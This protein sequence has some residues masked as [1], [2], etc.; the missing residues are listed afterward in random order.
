MEETKTEGAHTSKAFVDGTWHLVSF[1]T[2]LIDD[3]S[4]PVK[5][6]TQYSKQLEREGHAA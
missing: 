2:K 4:L 3:D 1:I 6:L 5:F